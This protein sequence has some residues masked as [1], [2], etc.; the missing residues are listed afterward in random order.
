MKSYSAFSLA[1]LSRVGYDVAALAA[2]FC[3]YSAIR[4]NLSLDYFVQLARINNIWSKLTIVFLVAFLIFSIVRYYSVIYGSQKNRMPLRIAFV[5]I[6]NSVF[7][8]IFYLNYVFTDALSFERI[9]FVVINW[10]ISSML[11]FIPR[12][13]RSFSRREVLAELKV[14]AQNRTKEAANRVLVIGGGGYIGSALVPRLLDSGM[15]VIVCDLFTFGEATLGEHANHPNLKI[16]KT[17]FRDVTQLVIHIRDVDNIIHLGGLV[18]DP[19]CA[20]DERLTI[21]I[22]VTATRIIAEI[23]KASGVRRFI[24]A[25][26]CSI[27]GASNEIVDETS[28]LNP[29]SLYA[30]TKVASEIVVSAMASDDFSPVYARF[31]T[32]YGISGRTRFDLVV[33]LLSAKAVT[34]GKI[35][36]FGSDQ[37]RPFVHVDDV[38]EALHMLLKAPTSVVHNE[39]FN[40]GSNEQNYTLMTV[41]EKIKAIVPTANILVTDENVDRRNYRVKFDKIRTRIGFTPHWT[42]EAG[43]RQVIEVVKE[44]K[45]TDL[46]DKLYSNV[47]FMRDDDSDQLRKNFLSGWEADLLEARH[48]EHQK[49]SA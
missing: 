30:Q 35:T 43:I 44:N 19:A 7:F 25:S 34:D 13:I 47:A 12:V 49:K 37:W 38:A 36:V 14:S 39:A 17:D 27:Y 1:N 24:F 33:N 6:G 16:V 11:M 5:L 46:H 45:I 4:D 22:N 8:F 10:A 26:S 9:R 20:V 23:A 42:M 41:A 15:S 3:I 48:I 21:D 31:G 29:Q 28:R 2:A 32:I 18:G 40:V